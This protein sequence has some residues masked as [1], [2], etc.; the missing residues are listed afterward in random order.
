M[1]LKLLYFCCF[2]LCQIIINII[3][4]RLNSYFIYKP[5]YLFIF[6]LISE[7]FGGVMTPL[8]AICFNDGNICLDVKSAVSREITN[9]TLNV[10]LFQHEINVKL[11]EINMKFQWNSREINYLREIFLGYSLF[12]ILLFL[13]VVGN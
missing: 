7:F 11:Y 2:T 1:P 8:K 13:V 3:I 6:Q 5:L 12:L 9:F 10:K 4:P